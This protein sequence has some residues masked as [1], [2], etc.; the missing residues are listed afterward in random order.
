MQAPGCSTTNNPAD[1]TFPHIWS[2]ARTACLG[3]SPF[4][5]LP[6]QCGAGRQRAAAFTFN[7]YNLRLLLPTDCVTHKQHLEE[8]IPPLIFSAGFVIFS[9]ACLISP[10]G[11]TKAPVWALK[12]QESPDWTR[13]SHFAETN[14]LHFFAKSKSAVSA[15]TLRRNEAVKFATK[16]ACGPSGQAERGRRMVSSTGGGLIGVSRG[17]PTR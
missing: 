10:S 1:Q 4:W 11:R 12:K 15:L 2:R 3:A 8:T 14:L 7:R 17:A 13:L 9:I 5:L 16:P 6:A